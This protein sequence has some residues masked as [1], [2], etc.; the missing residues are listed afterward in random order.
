MRSDRGLGRQWLKQEGLDASRRLVVLHPG[1]G[2]RHKC[3]HIENFIALADGL[4]RSRFE[5]LFL[6]GPAELERL[7][8][9]D[10]GRLRDAATCAAN[11]PLSQV[12]ARLSCARAFVG[13]D[14]GVTHLAAAMGLRT[15]A[16]FGP[17]DP[18]Q[19]AP[20]GPALKVMCDSQSRFAAKPYPK[21]QKAVLDA[22]C[23]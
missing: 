20:I 3:W 14:S 22:L 16:L 23:L 8:N 4:R 11:L 19:Y 2:G 7:S 15:I 18:T 13:N 1:S 9:A 5:V 17:T 6:L 12:V 21:L 10:L